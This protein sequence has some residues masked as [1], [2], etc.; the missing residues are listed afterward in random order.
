MSNTF[1]ISGRL[2][3]LEQSGKTLKIALYTTRVLRGQDGPQ[4]KQE[5]VA[6]VTFGPKAEEVLATYA[7]GQALKLGGIIRGGKYG[8]ELVVTRHEPIVKAE[9]EAPT[10]EVAPEAPPELAEGP[11]AIVEVAPEPIVETPK[12]K[13]RKKQAA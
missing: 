4:F 3:H 7:V 6:L 5:R 12:R 10:A 1:E 9:V 13:G 8:N 11:E 2:G